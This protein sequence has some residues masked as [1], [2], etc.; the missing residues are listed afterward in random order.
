V[1]LAKMTV[2]LA[3]QNLALLELNW[4]PLPP[5]FLSQ[6][7]GYH[8]GHILDNYESI[9]TTDAIPRFSVAWLSL[10]VT[11]CGNSLPRYHS[12]FF[13]SS[14]CLIASQP[15]VVCR[16]RHSAFRNASE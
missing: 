15:Q 11:T 9:G 3:A 5:S 14:V 1:P 4:R 7:F 10:D 8:F 16:S 13:R 12:S 6:L 2:N